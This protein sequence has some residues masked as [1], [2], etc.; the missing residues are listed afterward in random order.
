MALIYHAELCATSLFH[1][2]KTFTLVTA[3]DGFTVA[4][5]PKIAEINAAAAAACCW[6]PVAAKGNMMS[7]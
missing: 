7:W 1:L 6:P 3:R 2:T 5:L 4:K